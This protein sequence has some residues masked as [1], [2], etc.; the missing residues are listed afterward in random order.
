MHSTATATAKHCASTRVASRARLCIA[1]LGLPAAP[2]RGVRLRWV[3]A[4]LLAAGLPPRHGGARVP[5]A[6]GSGEAVP[7]GVARAEHGSHGGQSA[8]GGVQAG[9]RAA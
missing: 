5:G 4:A 8:G 6:W 9:E 2:P 3:L 7:G 1:G